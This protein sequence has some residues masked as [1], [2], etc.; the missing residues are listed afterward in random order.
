M[1]PTVAVLHPGEMG[2]A[3]AAIAVRN[4]E[5]LSWL[6]TDR[7][8]ATTKRAAAAG[9]TAVSKLDDIVE[10]DI[11]LSICP[12]AYAEAVASE[13]A[14]AG[15]SGLYVD[16]NAIS[17]QRAATIARKFDNFVDG[18]IVGP[19][20]TNQRRNRFYLS[21]QADHVS[22]VAALFRES[23][24]A[25]IDLGTET[26]AASALKMAYG[27][28]N[29]ATWALAAVAHALAAQYGVT[30][31]LLAE[32]ARTTTSALSE[33]DSLPSMVGRAWRWAPEMLEVAD[34]M[35]AAGLP[36][37]FGRAAAAVLEHWSGDK[38]DPGITAEEFFER[39]RHDQ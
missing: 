38:D 37:D 23:Q 34:T 10:A 2:A 26:G 35:R 39:L 15:F 7:S 11:V 3:M 1:P 27:G 17:P 8:Q 5:Q 33:L 9:L 36:D 30:E 28:Y 18:A 12:P 32:G 13:I 16:A 29:K 4:T 24:V 14:G 22:T 20:P 21:G 6:S 31:H 25:T 19:P